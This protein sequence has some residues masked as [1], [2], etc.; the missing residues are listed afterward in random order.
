[1]ARN[2]FFLFA[3]QVA[4]AVLSLILTAFLGRWLGVVEFGNYYLLMVCATFAY[5]LVDWGQS[6]YLIREAVRRR[7]DGGR[8][9]GSALT[10]RTAVAL[11]AALPAAALV[12][13]IGYGDRT[14]S[15]SLLAILSGVPL[16]L[17][18]AYGYMFR[19]QNRMDL[20]A[21]VAVIG[22][23]LTV[24]VTVP[25]L[26]LGGKLPAVVLFQVVGGLGSLLV[27]VILA[28]KCRLQ[29]RPPELG[30]LRDLASGGTPIAL[31]FLARAVQ[32]FI[33]AIVLVALVPQEV[34]GWYGAARAIIAL[35]CAPALIICTSSFPEFARVADSTPDLRLV[36]S[37]S[38]R[39]LLVLGALA[40]VGTFMFADVAVSIIYGG[41]HFEPAATL[42]QVFAVVLPILFIDMLLAN[43]ITAVGK[44]KEIA[45]VKALSVAISTGLAALLIPLCQT[46]FGNGAIGLILAFVCVEIL[47]LLAFIWLI[48]RG[49]IAPGSL[50]DCLR[51]GAVASGTTIV[52]WLLSPI[53]PWLGVPVCIVV[54]I[55]L[56]VA[57]GLVRKTDLEGLADFKPRS[58]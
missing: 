8:L 56:L 24:A 49:A 47:V 9:L 58:S 18:Q 26:L 6:A 46:R 15:L 38:W 17:S 40:M 14:A 51:A 48:P 28:R 16:A 57:I 25:V 41:R 53:T 21:S 35:L 43:A 55:A 29:A 39:L 36:L 45:L 4:T 42:L 31:F 11:M 20:D 22:K 2:T 10:F 1:L 50:L 44:T 27:A 12:K 52:H 3:G 54:F 5:V 23:A 7:E 19:S 37:A 13:L 34:V 32:P 33:D 30:L